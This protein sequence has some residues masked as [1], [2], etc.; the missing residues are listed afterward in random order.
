MFCENPVQRVLWARNYRQRSNSLLLYA[1]EPALLLTDG[2]WLVL[3]TA[4]EALVV[5]ADGVRI[6]GDYHFN[7]ENIGRWIPAFM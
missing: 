5:G 4:E 2:E 7:G 1:P 3:Q 6:Q